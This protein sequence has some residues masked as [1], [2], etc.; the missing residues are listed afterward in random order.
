LTPPVAPPGTRSGDT[1]L[2]YDGLCVLCDGFA[3]FVLRQDTRK[4]FRL[5]P[6]QG[7]VARALIPEFA[8]AAE[9]SGG[10]VVLRVDGETFLKSEAVLRLLEGLGGAWKLA[11]LL[12]R[13]MPRVARDA[14]YDVVARNRSRWFGRRTSCRIE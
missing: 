2:F 3:L 8:A 5:E 7:E 9:G 4:A 6:L 10:S 12:A 13:L 11:A 1:I 14:V